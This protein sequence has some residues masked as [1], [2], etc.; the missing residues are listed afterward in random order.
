MHV[1]LIKT[2]RVGGFV[3]APDGEPS[4]VGEV[5]DAYGDIADF[6]AWQPEKPERWWLRHGDIAVLGGHALAVAAFHGDRIRLYGTPQ[7]WFRTRQRGVCILLWDAPLDGIF[8]GV[9][10]VECDS[11]ELQ[12]RYV[13][14]LRRWEPPVIVRQETRH[15][16]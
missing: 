6:V 8:D 11:P 9:G 4:I 13:K 15:E 12:Q 5:R 10:A 1:L 3:L 16:T 2:N 14:A 7:D